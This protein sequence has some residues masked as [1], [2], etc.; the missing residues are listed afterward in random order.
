[1]FKWKPETDEASKKAISAG[2]DRMA[3]LDMVVAYHHGPDVGLADGTW[4]YV[5]VADFASVDDYRSYGSDQSHTS[6][7][8]DHIAPHVAD[9]AAVQY[10][11]EA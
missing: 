3:K 11:I 4:D 6:L 1:M 2:L 10:E 8:A 5:L 9:R 7:I